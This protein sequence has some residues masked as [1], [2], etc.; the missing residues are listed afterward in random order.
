M[1]FFEEIS[2]SQE[3]FVFGFFLRCFTDMDVTQK[4]KPPTAAL[5]SRLIPQVCLDVQVQSGL[6]THSTTL[7]RPGDG[8]DN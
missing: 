6:V 5:R 3:P 8:K 4:K 1:Q 2:T 7:T